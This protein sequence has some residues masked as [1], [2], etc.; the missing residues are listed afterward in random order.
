MFMKD[1]N[2]YIIYN[3]ISYHWLGIITRL[4]EYVIEKMYTTS[5][6]NFL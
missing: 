4:S 3:I 2:H 6:S 5:K 1:D